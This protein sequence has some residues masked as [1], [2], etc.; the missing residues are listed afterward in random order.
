LPPTCGSRDRRSA[1]HVLAGQTRAQHGVEAVEQLEPFLVEAVEPARQHRMHQRFLAAEVIVDRGQID[2][3]A[4]GNLPQRHRL[5][6]AFDEHRFGGVENAG[7]RI[8]GVPACGANCHI[9]S[10][11]CR[12]CGRKQSLQIEI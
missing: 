6:A 3:G 12:A 7:F 4:R 11:S 8:A 9:A 5:I 2:L 10:P 1:E